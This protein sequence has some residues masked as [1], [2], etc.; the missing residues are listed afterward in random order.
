MSIP[1]GDMQALAQAVAETIQKLANLNIKTWEARVMDYAT[2]TALTS[3]RIAI[4]KTSEAELKNM[5]CKSVKTCYH[6][7]TL[8]KTNELLGGAKMKINEFGISMRFTYPKRSP[9]KNAPDILA[10]LIDKIFSAISQLLKLYETASSW[11]SKKSG[12]T[13]FS[14]R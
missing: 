3:C 7:G 13:D 4:R 9:I 11:P 2:R 14:Q 10:D 5:L 12:S 1:S 8:E 6:E